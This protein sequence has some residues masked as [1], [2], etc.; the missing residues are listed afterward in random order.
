M[1]KDYPR[2]ARS[3]DNYATDWWLKNVFKG[4]FDP[5]PLNPDWEYDGLI[6]DWPDQTFVNPPYSDP[7]PWVE[8]AIETSLEEKTVVMLLKHD[9][10]TQW[11][12]RLHEANAH[13]LPI[14]GRVKYGTKRGAAFPSV[15]VVLEGIENPK[16]KHQLMNIEPKN[17]S[18]TDEKT[19]E[20]ADH[21][22]DFN[23]SLF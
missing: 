19:L 20:R 10:S 13:F 23:Q 21:R 14:S 1:K 2:K 4:W 9:S 18:N 12:R 8:K 17:A 16:S 7:L 11:W 15:L 3:H 6:M 22:L 5:C